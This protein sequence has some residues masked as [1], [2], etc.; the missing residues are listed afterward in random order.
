MK[1][2]LRLLCGVALLVCGEAAAQGA[3][4]AAD[5]A[6]A[7]LLAQGDYWRQQNRPELALPRYQRVLSVDPNNAAALAGAAQVQ[8]AL[9]DTAA[10]ETL[11]SRLRQVTTRDDP[12]LTGLE[13]A[14]RATGIRPE[15]LAEARRLAQT[16]RGREAISQYRTLFGGGTPPDELAVE[17][18]STLAGTEDG[19][20]AGVAGLAGVARRTPSDARAQ[21]AY[22]QAL[23]W[24]SAT[25]AQG[26]ERLQAL[27]RLPQGA[28]AAQQ[29][30][31]QAVL[32]SGPT[33]DAVPQLQAYLAQYPDDAAV[34]SRLAEAQDPTRR[35]A[36]Q[37]GEQRQRGFAL[38]E[39]NQTRDAARQFE[40]ALARNP[41]DPDALGG[42]GIVRLREG[43]AAEAQD[44]LRR[45]IAAAPERAG[46]WQQALDGAGY[47]LDLAEGRR[48]AQ[49]GDTAG[50]EAVFRRAAA[51]QVSD[52]ADAQ[53][54][55]GDML[56]RRGDGRGAEEA[57]RAVLSRRPDAR[58]ALAGLARA[59]RRQDRVAEASD[60][61][62][63]L[64]RG[65]EEPGSASASIRR[66]AAAASDPATATALLR[67]AVAANPSDPW[68]R[69]DLAR[70]LARQGE[71]LEGR[72]IVE[73]LALRGGG[74]DAA[75]AAALFAESEDRLAD[76]AAWLDRVPLRGRSP[77]MA[78]L[79]ARARAAAEVEAA[80]SATAAG[81]MFEGRQR[82]L[83][84]AT[85]PDPTG[86]LVAA[87]IR[88]FGRLNDVRGA[89][90]AA[91][92]AS[93]PGRAQ[94]PSARL[95]IAS[96]MVGAGLEQQA[97]AM[98]RELAGDPRLSADERRQ[99]AALQTSAAIRT[100][101]RL[102]EQGNQAAAFEALRP[103]LTRDPMDPAA[104]A[105]LAR[106]Y[107][108]AQRPREAA[109]V[110]ETLLA[111]DPRNLDARGTAVDAAIAS[112]DLRRAEALIAEARALAPSDARVSIMDARVARAAGDPRR[113]MRSLEL[114]SEQRRSAT[115]GG[116]GTPVR[117]AAVSD[118]PFRSG[119]TFA[120]STVAPSD[121]L[122]AEIAREAQ[123]L[124]DET[125]SQIAF[126]PGVRTRSGSSGLD[127]LTEIGASAEARLPAAGGA[128]TVRATPVTIDAGAIDRDV[129][130][131]RRY[132]TNALA[133]T[134]GG[135]A[136]RDPS[137]SGV[138][139]QLVYRRDNFSADVASSPVG[140]RN[141]TILGGVEVAPALGPNLRLRVT[142]ERRSVTD[143]VLSWA[144]MED[145][146]TGTRWGNV[147]RSGG[148]AQ[149]ELSAGDATFYAGGGYSIFDGDNVR[150]NT[151][152]E[153][154]AGMAYRI[155]NRPEEEL[156]TGFNVTHFGYQRNLRYFTLGHGGYFSPQSYT[157][158]TV[159]ID[160]RVRQGDLS[161][162][163]GASIGFASFREDS[164]PYF[165]N[166]AGLQAT[167]EGRA[168]GDPTLRTRYDGQSQSGVVVGL[169]GDLEYRITQQLRLGG[170]LS[171]DRSAD[172]NEA[173]GLL[174]AR[175]TLD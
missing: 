171:F 29:A 61:E 41:S 173:R 124:R 48:L 62:R 21:L 19:Y 106:L 84:I 164:A 90:E 8:L 122:A 147:T 1:P 35:L 4:P 63:R 46:Q 146:R 71:G 70:L 159:P 137:A 128:V 163:L 126:A 91:R 52:P 54:A 130:T 145:R 76:A 89:E 120:A 133:G 148:H 160:W 102:N 99:V 114:A 87:V 119:S 127:R 2:S 16:G 166:D 13:S 10:A 25:R 60:I 24:Q 31:R 93:L 155:I 153:V 45:A 117:T 96:A 20:R 134:T 111:R 30:W 113:A 43:R 154:G 65:G 86:A 77:E 42:L 118:N 167:L 121:P 3:G 165:P 57:Y 58:E 67:S 83:A 168:A 132:G 131:N 138:G 79:A 17:F 80:V 59:L 39:A 169:R 14:A 144:G 174:Y 11:T 135:P 152:Y 26:I 156:T 18:Y 73:D 38:L 12:R 97:I 68:A 51:R 150:D 116:L 72:A 94:T 108:G 44:L 33:E 49:R 141:T 23:T 50:A 64:P 53:I 5:G 88:G 82:L 85:R 55:L 123:R 22:A 47:G 28:A 69:L 151:R 136:P 143:S 81:R 95:V 162:R 100:A 175:Y 92:I 110:A 157:A 101:D 115:G 170:L 27:A 66:R 129:N 149:L 15:A 36:M 9:G 98:A 105:A 107:Q 104:N 56:L 37:A 6:I 125:A 78:A 158:L 172:Y 112:R 139:F 103:V 75:F 32:W 7:A 34:R 109:E 40:D 142:G 140:F 74:A 161:W